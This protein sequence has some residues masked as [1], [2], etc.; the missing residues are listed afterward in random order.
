MKFK[1][2]TFKA[3]LKSEKPQIGLWVGLANSYTA[4]MIA[5]I[6]YDWLLLDGEHAPNNVL[7]LLSQLQA[8]APYEREGVSHP[9][10]RPL[11]GSPAIIKQL[12]D[13]GVKTLLIP[14]VE[15][16][17]QAETYVKSMW[18]PPKGIRG[19]G[20]ALARASRWNQ[21]DDYLNHAD[22][23]MCLLLQIETLEGVKNL[24]EIAGLEGV[25]G[26]FIGPADLSASMGHRGNPSHP[27]VQMVIEEAL[28][29]IKAHGKAA[30]ILYANEERAKDY[31]KMG[32]NF[33]AVGVDTSILVKS[34]QTLLGKF[35][36]LNVS[37][38]DDDTSVY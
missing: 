37:N 38:K 1:K 34:C 27:E 17:E 30:G 10:I 31:I 24:D 2:N 8:I 32:Y 28:K 16:K 23:E 7:T 4:E 13:L 14:M 18:Y 35:K 29:V 5:S 12:L 21:V 36:A 3:A 33:V 25:D 20:S 15:T 9:V 11:E 6:G 26:I 19:V 22:D